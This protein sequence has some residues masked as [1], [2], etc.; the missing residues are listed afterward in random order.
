MDDGYTVRLRENATGEIRE[1]R[2]LGRWEDWCHFMWTDGNYGCDCNRFLLFARAGGEDPSWNA[3][4]CGESAYTAI[5]ALLPDGRRIALDDDA[6]PTQPA[7][8]PPTQA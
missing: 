1:V 8:D 5:D 4:Q 3:G 7:S 2:Q 6:T